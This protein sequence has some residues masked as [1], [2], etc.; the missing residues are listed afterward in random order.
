[1]D[2]NSLFAEFLRIFI[3]HFL[4]AL[5]NDIA[6]GLRLALFLLHAK[7]ALLALVKSLLCVLDRADVGLESSELFQVLN[8]AL[9]EQLS[10]RLIHGVTVPRQTWLASLM[11]GVFS[12]L[13]QTSFGASS[14]L[15]VRLSLVDRRIVG[16]S[17]VSLVRDARE[18]SNHLLGVFL[19]FCR[20]LQNV[21]AV[22]VVPRLFQITSRLVFGFVRRD[23]M[24]RVGARHRQEVLSID[25]DTTLLHN[26]VG[27]LRPCLLDIPEELIFNTLQQSPRELA[28]ILDGFHGRGPLLSVQFTVSILVKKLTD[29]VVSPADVAITIEVKRR[30][31]YLGLA[32]LFNQLSVSLGPTG[33]FMLPPCG[34][35]NS[36][37]VL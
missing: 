1:M 16:V 36:L 20:L 9:L 17:D 35:M 2:S 33:N 26:A 25:E 29:N 34:H 14:L 13:S 23:R 27:S 30:I 7:E 10:T 3:D 31:G 37:R 18:L 12:G 21:S 32:S 19:K 28:Y 5:L 8:S 4:A 15:I 22:C 24:R 11:L 6:L